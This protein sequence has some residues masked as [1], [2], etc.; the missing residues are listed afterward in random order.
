[1][2]TLKQNILIFAVLIFA[3][4][5][6]FSCGP[7]DM[8]GKGIIVIHLPGSSEG[9]AF[10]LLSEI[11]QIQYL[12]ELKYKIICAGSGSV[13]ERDV[14]PGIAVTL[15]L[16]A[17][18]WEIT[19]K[20]INLNGREV[21]SVTKKENV[22]AN[23]SRSVFYQIYLDEPVFM[24][25]QKF[26]FDEDVRPTECC[27][28]SDKLK[29]SQFFDKTLKSNTAY[30]I[31][32]KGYSTGVLTSVTGQIY[33]DG[34]FIDITDFS[35]R[36]DNYFNI[37][38]PGKFEHTFT[39]YAN[40][41]VIES[42]NQINATFNFSSDYSNSEDDIDYE[43]PNNTPVAA[44]THF[45]MTIDE[46]SDYSIWEDYKE[47]YAI[48]I[49]NYSNTDIVAFKNEIKAENIIGGIRAASLNH[50]IKYDK[51][52]FP[53]EPQQFIVRF[54]SGELYESNID[55]LSTDA[56]LNQL[57]TQMH[58]FW[59]GDNSDQFRA[60][61]ISEKLGGPNRLQIINSSD[62]H[63]GYR[64]DGPAGKI[65]YFAP[66]GLL[67]N[68]I[69]V[70]AGDYM[71]VPVLQRVNMI[72]DVIETVVPMINE[73]TPYCWNITFSGEALVQS[74]DLNTAVT[75][76]PTLR[77]LGAAYVLINNDSST[78]VRFLRGAV[79]MI[80]PGGV[81]VINSGTN[82]EFMIEMPVSSN[83]YSFASSLLVG[84]FKI[85]SGGNS[86]DVKSADGSSA[87]SLAS[88]KSYAITV[89]GSGNAG[90]LQAMIDLND[91]E[92]F[93]VADF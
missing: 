70:S 51:N 27:F 71:I 33:L 12:N 87:F 88:G 20:A 92:D 26:N 91:P 23:K 62:F 76:A 86:V 28:S 74:I 82:R 25:Y 59:N 78:G 85:I 53:E 32:V 40:S 1:M 8:K 41:N 7:E 54:I 44:I 6:F 17:G 63:V 4:M 37:T 29:I 16:A 60:Y 10:R 11:E 50:G 93:V 75:E 19:V 2:K 77:S 47:D 83:G 24:R 42:Y 79:P 3:G 72:R 49:S 55:N 52:L 66:S 38:H 58:V 14:L 46:E 64:L 48:R 80:T 13:T 73:N 34:E 69:Y 61:E 18:I 65:L 43:T 21:G 9:G 81:Q 36:N 90:T 45:N 30:K 56:L 31:S 57:F 67:M 35:G 84:N 89:T 15:E 22:E 39:L 5:F 68:Y